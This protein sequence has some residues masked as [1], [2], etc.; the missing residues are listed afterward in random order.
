MFYFIFF[1]LFVSMLMFPSSVQALLSMP[2]LIF[3]TKIHCHSSSPITLHINLFTWTWRPA[4]IKLLFE[5]KVAG[6]L[7]KLLCWVWSENVLV[8]SWEWPFLWRGRGR[9]NRGSW[10]R[11]LRIYYPETKKK[12]YWRKVP[13]E[14]L[15]SQLIRSTLF[16]TGSAGMTVRR[17]DMTEGDQPDGRMCACM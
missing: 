6:L 7:T 10:E 17:S 11:L 2:N 15:T 5:G 14:S 13:K 3:N 4:S 1:Y 9:G 16:R 12:S 8:W